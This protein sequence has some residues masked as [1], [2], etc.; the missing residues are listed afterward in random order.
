MRRSQ[1]LRAISWGLFAVL[2]A[3]VALLAGC[4]A[5][6]G[7]YPTSTPAKL[8]F[9]NAVGDVGPL[10][11][12]YAG[13]TISN[14]LPFEGL[15]PYQSV[16]EGTQELKVSVAG[17]NTTLID[18]TYPLTGLQSYTVL[19]FGPSTSGVQVLL[20][21]QVAEPGGGTFNLRI[22]NA[23]TGTSALD[24]YLTAPG[25][26]LDTVTPALANLAYPATSAFLSLPAGTYQIRF[27]TQGSKN[28]IYDGGTVTFND[29]A[30]FHLVAYTKGSST[31]V[32]AA[33]LNLDTD[34]TGALR[35]NT[36]A[37]FKVIHAAPGTGAVNAFVDGNLVLSNVTYLGVSSYELVSASPH[38]ISI[39]AATSPGAPIATAQPPF[40]AATDASV[41]LTGLPGAQK[42]LVLSDY[43]LPGSTGNAR[44]RFVNV[45]PDAG[46]VDVYVNFVE[47]VPA[48]ASSAASDYFEVAGGRPEV[49]NEDTYTINFLQSGTTNVVL[50]LPAV[51]VTAAHTYTIYLTGIAG[52]YSGIV[53]R[54]D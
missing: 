31:L 52:Q 47:R 43:N 37:Q 46:P 36:L 40:A 29:R 28:V 26:P 6:S 12:T 49:P 21:D 7:G 11:I 3:A 45:S 54:D 25:A 2:A 23:A 16:T 44:L 13:N 1:I 32:N 39:E 4:N 20:P 22:T 8:R 33:L 15:L 50:S 42:A 48:L 10:V 38:T 9:F 35:D 53:T 5:K 27:T 41:V 14:G 51:A 24:V 30:S 17:S 18:T 19:L 34:G